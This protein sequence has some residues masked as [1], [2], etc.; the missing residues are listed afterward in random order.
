MRKCSCKYWCN[1]HPFALTRKPVAHACQTCKAKER[2]FTLARISQQNRSTIGSGPENSSAQRS[3]PH[4]AGYT[5]CKCA[6]QVV[7]LCSVMGDYARRVVIRVSR[8]GL[9][10]DIRPAIQHCSMCRERMAHVYALWGTIRSYRRTPNE[11]LEEWARAY[12]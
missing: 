2:A 7:L 11:F 9:F 10:G 4:A 1:R 3:H 6:W 5:P 12:L 8:L